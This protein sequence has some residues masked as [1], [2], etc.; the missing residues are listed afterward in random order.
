M[1]KRSITWGLL[2]GLMMLGNAATNAATGNADEQ[3]VITAENQ[4]AKANQTN[5]VEM[6]VSFLADQYVSTDQDGMVLTGK[7]ANVADYKL[8]NFSSYEI[9][10]LKVM[11]FGN[12]AVATGAYAT[13]GTYKGKPFDSHG[14]FTDTWVKHDGKWQTV[15]SHYSH[16][17]K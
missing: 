5:N 7:A 12:A 9:S 14:R 8:A 17:K 15:A 6:A 13:K 16:I 11:V 10:D 1:N 4:V 3:A 2:A